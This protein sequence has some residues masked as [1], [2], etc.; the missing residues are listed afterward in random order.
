M[1]FGYCDFGMG[2]IAFAEYFGAFNTEVKML[3]NSFAVL[4]ILKSGVGFWLGIFVCIRVCVLNW[5]LHLV[6]IS[7]E[8]KL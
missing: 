3:R 4:M 7:D 6:D 5:I 1:V 8:L 2:N